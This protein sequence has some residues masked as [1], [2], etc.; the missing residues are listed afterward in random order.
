MKRVLVVSLLVAALTVGI[1]A[2]AWGVGP[3]V[4][5]SL[6][7]APGAVASVGF[8]WYFDSWE[9]IAQ[10]ADLNAWYGEWSI[11]SLWTPALG[12][13]AD[14]RL[15]ARVAWVWNDVGLYYGPV[16]FVVGLQHFWGIPGI[17]LQL[18]ASTA[19]V[20]PRLGFELQIPLP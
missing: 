11:G 2:V 14:L 6:E 10:K 4:N 20:V 19:S 1:G 7:P 9:I 17:W 18:E 3:L 8:G 12:S 5:L 13:L 15:G 16:V